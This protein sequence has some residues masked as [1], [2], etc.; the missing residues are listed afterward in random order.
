MEACLDSLE[1]SEQGLLPTLTTCPQTHV[2]I[3]GTEFTVQQTLFNHREV[4][5]LS[6]WL[7]CTHK[8]TNTRRTLT[9]YSFSPTQIT[10]EKE[11]ERA[12][13]AQRCGYLLCP[14]FTKSQLCMMCDHVPE[15]WLAR[16]RTRPGP[17]WW[18]SSGGTRPE[19][20]D[21][22]EEH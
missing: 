4:R 20:S 13:S 19:D 3:R 15:R 14:S 2:Y 10:Q 6:A 22:P 18:W 5:R 21:M 17:M 9:N 1:L 12:Q 7:S 16:F 11:R 8:Y